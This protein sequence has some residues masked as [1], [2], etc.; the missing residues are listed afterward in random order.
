MASPSRRW[1]HFTSTRIRLNEKAATTRLEG[2]YRL[3]SESWRQPRGDRSDLGWRVVQ[4]YVA[5]PIAD[6]MEDEK[7]IKKATKA[8]KAE[9]KALQDKKCECIFCLIVAS[10]LCCGG[11]ATINN[12][13]C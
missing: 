9:L 11:I 3:S 12:L 8:A 5:D 4:H 6:D 10:S 2:R 13:S 7:R 1:R